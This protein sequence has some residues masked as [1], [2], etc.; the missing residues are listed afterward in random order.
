METDSV[1]EPEKCSVCEKILIEGKGRF[2]KSEVVFC[3]ECYAEL[4]K[5]ERDSFE[6]QNSVGIRDNDRADRL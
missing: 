3:M 4:N 2:R 1:N 5:N 6:K